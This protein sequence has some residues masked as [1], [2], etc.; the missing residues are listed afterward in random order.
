MVEHCNSFAS[1]DSS[2][3]SLSVFLI[4]LW[5]VSSI[6][7]SF[8]RHENS[9][10][11]SYEPRWSLE[12]VVLWSLCWSADVVG[13]PSSHARDWPD[14]NAPANDVTQ[15]LIYDAWT[16]WTAWLDFCVGTWSQS[17]RHN[18]YSMSANP[19][20]LAKTR[21]TFIAYQRSGPIGCGCF[22]QSY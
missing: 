6:L 12:P 22:S 21:E 15:I 11:G 13:C 16:P 18:L 10:T 3:F 2:W 9:E 19:F 17:T 4:A 1:Y 7:H 8:G 20:R 5:K 14:N